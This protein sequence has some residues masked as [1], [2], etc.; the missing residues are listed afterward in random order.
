MNRFTTGASIALISLT[1]ATRPAPA[2]P[3]SVPNQNTAEQTMLNERSRELGQI[4]KAIDDSQANWR[5]LSSEIEG[6]LNK[7]AENLTVEG[8]HKGAWSLQYLPGGGLVTSSYFSRVTEQRQGLD[9]QLSDTEQANIK[10]QLLDLNTLREEGFL[11]ISIMNLR[12][13]E[14]GE[15]EVR[16]VS[17]PGSKARALPVDSAQ[18]EDFRSTEGRAQI[19]ARA[20]E[21]FR[22][23]QCE[24]RPDFIQHSIERYEKLR[25]HYAIS[26]D[27]FLQ[28][29][30][31]AMLCNSFTRVDTLRRYADLGGIRP[32]ELGQVPPLMLRSVS[33]ANYLARNLP[34][35]STIEVYNA[36]VKDTEP[37]PTL[38]GLV[39]LERLAN[40]V[41]GDTA[42]IAQVELKRAMHYAESEIAKLS[43]PKVED[44]IA[45][46]R[47][48]FEQEF[49]N[50][51]RFRNSFE[52]VASGMVIRRTD[53]ST[54]ALVAREM[55]RRVGADAGAEVIFPQ[56]D[57]VD[58]PGLPGHM[59]NFINL[60]D[61][62]RLYVDFTTPSDGDF[63]FP[64]HEEIFRRY[65][66][67]SGF[68]PQIRMS[69]TDDSAVLS[70]TV[71]EPVLQQIKAFTAAFAASGK[72]LEGFIADKPE[73][74]DLVEFLKNYSRQQ[75][76]LF[77]TSE[78]P[79][80]ERGTQESI[81]ELYA[82]FF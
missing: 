53:C 1:Q 46:V 7:L 59:Y 38:Y 45:I 29:L 70:V 22:L 23:G 73:F 15:L 78:S 69:S 3:D 71:R 34:S 21:I 74:K 62:S 79:L 58:V 25:D 54:R 28:K 75:D 48:Y 63:S 81:R 67:S 2:Q 5:F 64:D 41:S 72:D 10:T 35:R 52:G 66:G 11:D 82:Q 12:S 77:E 13:V 6:R 20:G 24:D 9:V 26:G 47:K 55:L 32:D 43:E 44:A 19:W 57:G 37:A 76:K 39:E 17:T 50:D 49:S 42:A 27:L 36:R 60:S 31:Q 68:T 56:E 16:L 61:G 14:T 51:Y 30:A 65:V 4:V 8:M 18:V 40:V 33:Y 80:W